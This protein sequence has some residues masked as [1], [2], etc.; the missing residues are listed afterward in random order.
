MSCTHHRM[1]RVSNSFPRSSLADS[2]AP[3]KSD[4]SM[5]SLYCVLLFSMI[6]SSNAL[7][8]EKASCTWLFARVSKNLQR[9]KGSVVVAAYT[10]SNIAF[11]SLT[12]SAVLSWSLKSVASC[13]KSCEKAASPITSMVNRCASKS[14]RMPSISAA[15]SAAIQRSRSKPAFLRTILPRFSFVAPRERACRPIVRKSLFFSPFV[16]TSPS[17]GSSPC[18]CL[19]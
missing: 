12:K 15:S 18:V 2:K 16:N 9:P 11:A 6:F 7:S 14:A 4:F 10:P 17:M 13:L 5:P 3:R 1:T 8:L 19:S